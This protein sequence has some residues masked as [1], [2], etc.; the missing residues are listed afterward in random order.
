LLQPDLSQRRDPA[1]KNLT[2]KMLFRIPL[3]PIAALA[4]AAALPWVRADQA[5]SAPA[6]QLSVAP[7][8]GLEGELEQG[9]P[10]RVV[11]RIEVRDAGE[12]RVELA[13]T[14]GPWTDA[15]WVELL[16]T[17]GATAVARAEVIGVPAS[18]R[19]TLDRERVAGGTWVFPETATREL[20]PGEY[21]VRARLVLN[22]AQGWSG[23][24]ASEDVPLRLIVPSNAP[25]RVSAR[26]LSRAQIAFARGAFEEAAQLLDRVL[27]EKPD[28]FDLLCLRAEVA[29]A[30]GNTAAAA[31][32]ANRAARLV[33]PEA[34]GPPPLPLHAVQSAVLA[35]WLS[36]ASTADVPAWTWP[37][38]AVLRQVDKEALER[39]EKTTAVAKAADV[40][41]RPTSTVPPPRATPT[42]APVASKTP[43]PQPEAPRTTPSPPAPT[44]QVIAASPQTNKP[45]IGTVVPSSELN[46]AKIKA[47]AAGQW[48]ASATAGT[49]Y[50]RGTQYSPNQATGV[51]NVTVAGNS[52]NAWCPAV[53][54]RGM[55]WFEATFA[56]AVRA[57]EV[58]VRQ[59]DGVGAIVKVEAIEPNGTTHVWWEGVDPYQRGRV[60]EVVWFAVRVPPTSYPVARVK[61]TLNLAAGPGYKQIDA[62]QLV[63]ANP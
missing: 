57:T 58:R 24:V 11:V 27:A 40:V 44:A 18:P 45:P 30:G 54:D 32:C 17:G 8:G 33:T 46:D 9:E 22:G 53:A 52:P 38:N 23:E 63:G 48:A 29:L 37:P 26:T 20:S 39:M 42:S 51:P 35:A 16:P 7:R 2:V 36:P 10:L 43:P 49:Q 19:A 41:P 50:G 55:D 60:R 12:H 5:T 3:F 31:V 15:I 4:F 56:N 25:E 14:N 59:N 1:A 6:P 13:P 61:L 47:E 28:D 62:V 34:S 21:V